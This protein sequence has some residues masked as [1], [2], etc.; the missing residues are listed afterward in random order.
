MRHTAFRPLIRHATI[1][2]IRK[3]KYKCQPRKKYESKKEKDLLT[4]V[5]AVIDSPFT[6]RHTIIQSP[7]R[8]SN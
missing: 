8:E 4:F 2:N 1:T 7:H 5:V 3:N 6:P